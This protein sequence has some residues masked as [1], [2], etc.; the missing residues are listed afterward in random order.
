MPHPSLHA[1]DEKETSTGSAL[2]IS[3]YVA[4]SLG[5][6]SVVFCNQSLTK[7]VSSYLTVWIVSSI[8]SL[9]EVKSWLT[10]IKYG[11]INMFKYF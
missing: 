7:T 9:S 11:K 8:F 3:P 1:N 2:L 4:V 10:M 5:L 6:L